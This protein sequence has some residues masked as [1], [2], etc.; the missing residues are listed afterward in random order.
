M[1]S[2]TVWRNRDL[3]PE[4]ETGS[5]SQAKILKVVDDSPIPQLAV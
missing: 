2:H 5:N 3:E 1:D 4:A